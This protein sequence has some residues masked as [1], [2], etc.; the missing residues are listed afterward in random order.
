MGFIDVNMSYIRKPN[1]NLNIT[2]NDN[3][4]IFATSGAL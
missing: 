1:I 3:I 2:A 4:V